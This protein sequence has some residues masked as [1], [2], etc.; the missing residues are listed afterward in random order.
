MPQKSKKNAGT[1]NKTIMKAKQKKVEDLTFGMKNKNKSKKVQAHIQSLSKNVMNSGDPKQRKLEEMRRAQ[2]AKQ[3]AAK[4]AAK[5]EQNALF[6]EALLA[7]K[8]KSTTDKKGGKQEA[9]GRDADD[10]GAK[11]AGTSRAM[12]LMYQMDAKEASDKLKEDPNYVFTIEDEIEKQ[13]LDLVEKLKKSGKKGTP[14][15]QA[16]FEEWLRKKQKRKADA[17]KKLVEAEMRKKKGGK[18]L[19]ILSGRDLYNYNKKLFVDQDTGDDKA[20]INNDKKKEDD[21][22]T[23]SST[24]NNIKEEEKQDTTRD[25]V[26][27]IVDKVKSELFLDEDDDISLDDLDDD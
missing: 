1:S 22:T 16:T 15:T 18:G 23:T 6:G 20:I 27:N 2:K 11:K 7:V 3:K 14:I 10:E 12:K 17:A 5:E 13:R 4:K 8:K 9:K 24:T 26:E 21:T 25:N 19:S